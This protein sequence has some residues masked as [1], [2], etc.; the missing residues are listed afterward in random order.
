M[1]Y[2]RIYLGNLILL[3]GFF[4]MVISCK[5]TSQKSAIKI[6][7]VTTLNDSLFSNTLNKYVN[8]RYSLP[9]NYD[10]SISVPIIYLLHGHGGSSKDWF[11]S[12]GGNAVITL[13]QMAKDNHIPPMIGVSIS[14]GNSWYVDSKE[15]WESFYINE[16]IPYFEAI[17]NFSD[18]ATD[19]HIAGLSAGGFGA[20]RFSLK[21]P[22]KFHNVILLSP[23]SY[24][25]SPPINSSAR[26]IAAFAID[27]VFNDSLWL[28]YSYKHLQSDFLK[29]V[30]KPKFHLSVGDDDVFNIVP[31][32]T[33]LQQFFLKNDVTN[34][35][36]IIN[37]GHDWECWNT[38]FKEALSVLF[39]PK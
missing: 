19:R 38:N 21:Y 6:D 26:K 8:Y 4:F 11:A 23:A 27:G 10:E 25:P 2:S 1:K 28:T 16:F 12:E 13:T 37:G 20:L 3:T 9:Q 5:N 17:F 29:S 33:D 36:R 14:A 35:L 22:S 32:V 18:T 7:E 31:V 30:S 24:E 34:E 15:D 39:T